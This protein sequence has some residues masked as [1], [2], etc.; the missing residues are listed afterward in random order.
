[1]QGTGG[2]NLTFIAAVLLL[3]IFNVCMGGEHSSSESEAFLKFIRAIDPQNKLNVSQN[4][5]SKPHPCLHN[6]KGLQ[7]NSQC[8]TI[9]EIW[10]ENLNLSGIL[11]TDSL[12]KIPNLRVISLARNQIRGTIPNSIL[13]CR[14][15][16]YLNLSSNLLSGR[17]PI[18]LTK[19]KHLRRL[20]ISNNS[21]TNSFPFY[22]ERFE[23]QSLHHR[24]SSSFVKIKENPASDNPGS[25]GSTQQE[26]WTKWIPWIIGIGLLSLS[27]YL[28]GKRIAKLSK[29]KEVLKSSLQDSPGTAPPAKTSEDEK[30]Q[31]REPELVLFVEEHEKFKLEELLEATADL[32][33]QSQCSSLFKVS[34]KN[35]GLYAV[36]RLK[37]VQASFE[38]FD[39]TMRQ[40]GNLKHPNILSLVGYASSNEE[41][42][43][44]YKYQSGGSLLSLLESKSR[45][46]YI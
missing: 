3:P 38:E 21:F 45:S 25:T 37:K 33:S 44:I 27:V 43:L 4:I 24:E 1:M 19:M 36:K 6:W 18:A 39:E 41:K 22:K 16:T 17:T 5:A 2:F 15:L 28:A 42:L 30:Q 23:Q 20:D 8:T 32:R 40:I 35:Y 29:S 11:D 7:C 12:C 10:F 31:E 34:L 26:K 14:K 9:L 46:D 13:Y